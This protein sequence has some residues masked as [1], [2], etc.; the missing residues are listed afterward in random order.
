MTEAITVVIAEDHPLFR[1]GLSDALSVDAS[2]R[3][4]GE[5]ADGEQ[6]LELLR[7]HR[8]RVALLDVDMPR[9]SGLAVA[10][11]VRQENLGAVVVMLTMYKD[12]AMLRRALDLGAKGYVLKDSALTDI[13]A[14]LHLVSSGRAYVSPALSSDLLERGAASATTELAAVAGLT[15]AERRVLRLIAQGLT[16]GGIA[17]RLGISVK[18]VEN[19]RL[20]IC[21]KLELHGPQALLRFALERKALLD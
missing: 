6:A 8:P 10:E 19:H 1:K 18:T 17:E 21:D 20:H 14:C 12:A 7:R 2:F 5:A 13:T 9:L 4:V 3:V 15:P 11:A 16:S